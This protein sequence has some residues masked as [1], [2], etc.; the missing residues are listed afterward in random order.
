MS[1]EHC[2]WRTPVRTPAAAN[3]SSVTRPSDIST[4][5]TPCLGRSPRGWTWSTPSRET[6]RSLR[7]ASRNRRLCGCSASGNDDGRAGLGRVRGAARQ[8]HGSPRAIHAHGD[9]A[10]RR[11]RGAY[12]PEHASHLYRRPKS[13][14]HDSAVGAG[15]R[16]HRS[17][18]HTSELQSRGHL[19]CRLLLEKKKKL[20]YRQ[21]FFR[22]I[23]T[24]RNFAITC[25]VML[26]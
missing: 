17:E 3:S 8:R 25:T 2:R 13:R 1:R 21:K 14:R 5:C 26:V 11:L 9:T 24:F 18:E 15:H 10:A 16:Q 6:T 22:N 19:V 4:E 23:V 7:F 20:E 12:A